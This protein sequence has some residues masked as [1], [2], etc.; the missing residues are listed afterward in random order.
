MLCLKIFDLHC[1][2]IGKCSD[3]KVSLLKNNMHF[4]LTGACEYESYTQVFAVWIKDELRGKPALDYFNKTADY[5]Y[6]EINKNK[7]LISLYGGNT[8]VKAV[9]S[10]EGGSACG[11][12]IDG[13][14]HLYDRGVR[15]ATL[16]WNSENEIAGGA[17]SNSGFTD[18]GKAFVKECKRLGVI[19]DVSH[20][21]RQSFKELES[22]YGGAFIASHSNADIVDRDYA[23]KRNLREF[24]INVIKERGGL[25]GI[26]YY[27]E[28]LET[29]N[30]KGVDAIKKQL[31]F[32][33]NNGCENIIALGSDYDGCR[34]GDELSGVEKLKTVYDALTLEFGKEIIDKLFYQNAENYFNSHIKY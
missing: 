1:D 16:T 15:L 31:N 34:I 8:P 28:F 25:M 19:I 12:T 14:Y 23:H 27:T 21:N 17:F 10:V 26:N 2:T 32:L 13:L 18:F 20:L 11:G 6:S 22:F 4:D 5:F 33:L 30:C 24:Q 3:N 9:L 29:E 7:N